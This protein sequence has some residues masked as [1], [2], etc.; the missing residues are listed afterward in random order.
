MKE[1][2]AVE[3]KL[4]DGT[5]KNAMIVY[6]IEVENKTPLIVYALDN[7]LYGAKYTVKDGETIL[8]TNLTEEEIEILNKSLKKLGDKNEW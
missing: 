8:D 7:N 5:T 2:D 4:K 6:T 3:L 1:N